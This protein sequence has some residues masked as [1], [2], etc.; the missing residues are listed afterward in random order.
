MDLSGPSIDVKLK[1]RKKERKIF[2][3]K[4]IE[5]TNSNQCWDTG[6]MF[7]WIFKGFKGRMWENLR[8]VLESQI[9]SNSILI[10]ST[11]IHIIKIYEPLIF[12]FENFSSSHFYKCQILS[13]SIPLSYSIALRWLFVSIM[14]QHGCAQIL[15][16]KKTIQLSWLMSVNNM[17]LNFHWNIPIY[18]SQFDYMW[19]RNLSKEAT[20]TLEYPG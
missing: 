7:I 11:T 10:F 17:K 9:L 14:L 16:V 3:K 6:K 1:E 8:I 12:I 13:H 15:H 19:L 20:L 5:K 18:G 4:F 2:C